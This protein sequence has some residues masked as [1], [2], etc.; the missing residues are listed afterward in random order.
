MDQT[1][2]TK[3]SRNVE[4]KNN[5]NNEARKAAEN[6]RLKLSLSGTFSSLPI[7]IAHY[8]Q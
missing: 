6:L 7:Y 1:T 3:I 8:K 4:E 2:N 5:F